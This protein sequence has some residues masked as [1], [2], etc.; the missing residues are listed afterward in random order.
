MNMEGRWEAI[1]GSVRDLIVEGNSSSGSLGWHIDGRMDEGPF[2]IVNE[3]SD[4]GGS[5][6]LEDNALSLYE[7]GRKVARFKLPE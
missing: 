5:F 7:N 3:P 4:R 1:S 2:C 6:V